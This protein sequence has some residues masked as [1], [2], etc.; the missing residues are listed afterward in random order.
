[1]SA[2]CAFVNSRSGAEV[3]RNRKELEA[4]NLKLI[5]V[6][7]AKS[8]FF[9]NISHELRTPLTLLI[10]PLEKLRNN[11]SKI[12]KQGE[13][14]DIMYGNAMRLL[15]LINDLLNLVRLDAGT[16]VLRKEKVEIKPFLE[17][18]ALSVSPMA[19]QSKLKFETQILAGE[20]E[21]VYLDRDKIR[22][23]AF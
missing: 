9:A 4:S 15:R 23:D 3:D 8:D 22:E 14:L 7:R 5:E 17:G 18:L 6:D 20:H 1:M 21:E 10:G 11:T 2:V 16:L 19:Q 13:L 12:E